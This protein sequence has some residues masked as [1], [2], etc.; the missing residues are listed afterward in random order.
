VGLAQR[1]YPQNNSTMKCL[2]CNTV[3]LGLVEERAEHRRP[4][5]LEV[6]VPL[7]SAL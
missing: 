6:T 2:I 1:L 7:E 4:P 5:S 3:V